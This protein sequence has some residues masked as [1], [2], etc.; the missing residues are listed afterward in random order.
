MAIHPVDMA[1]LEGMLNDMLEDHKMIVLARR[2]HL[3]DQ[4]VHLDSRMQEFL[5]LH[6]GSN[7]FRLNICKTVVN[8]LSDELTVVGFDTNEAADAQGIK[9]QA[10]WA[11]DVAAQNRMDALQGDVHLAAF[12]DRETFVIV[13]WDENNNRPRFT[14][15]SR[16]TDVAADGNGQGCWMVYENDDPNQ[17]ARCAVK[18][19]TEIHYD[20]SWQPEFI[21]R[22]NVYYADRIEKWLYDG[23]WRHYIDADVQVEVD[24]DGATPEAWPVPWVDNDGKPLGIPVIHF[25]NK[26]LMPEAWD[27]IPM[28]DAVNKS[29]VDVLATSDMSAFSLLAA[30]GF[31][32]TTDGQAPKAD[33]SNLLSIKPGSW[34]G[35]TKSKNDADVK[36][37]EGTDVTPAI[38]ALKDLIVLTAQITD[39]PVSRFVVSGQVAGEGTLKEQE[40]PLKKKASDRRVII[41]NGWEDCMVMAR[42][43]ENLYGDGGLDETVNFSTLW[44]HRETLDELK[45]KKELGVPE[46]TIWREMGY[47]EAQIAEMKKTDEYKLKIAK[48]LWDAAKVSTEAGFVLETFLRIMGFTDTQLADVGTQK[49]AAIKLQQEDKVPPV[50]Q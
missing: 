20:K 3:G 7:P 4:D 30:L 14:H 16:F 26:G 25:K 22:R 47:S 35:T 27:A 6:S 11:T 5:D 21:T 49:L 48:M 17:P 46:E 9:K 12:R 42:K 24:E 45:Q 38:N 33:G 2:Y 34:I 31:Y 50:K 39:T 44:A 37:I 36:K 41:G 1:I 18:Q 19:W 10:K 43:L 40:Q 29:L 32:P 28:Q 23:G 8:A 13:D 15:N